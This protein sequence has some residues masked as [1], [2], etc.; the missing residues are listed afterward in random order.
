MSKRENR[1][2][3]N[4]YL[5]KQLGIEPNK[6][7]RYTLTPEQEKE[8]KAIQEFNNDSVVDEALHRGKLKE[9][10]WKVAW[11]KEE[12]VSV[13]VKNPDYKEETI[14]YDT[15]RLDMIEE[16]KQLSTVVKQYKRKAITDPHCLVLDISDPHFGK[17]ATV[18]GTGSFYNVDLAIERAIEASEKLIDAS[19]PYNIDK[20]FF[21]IG[22]DVLHT[23]NTTGSTTKGTSQ[24]TDGMWYDN[25]KIV[26]IVYSQII[27]RLTSIAPVSVIH[28]PSNHDYMTGFML[29][30]AIS[31][32][33][34]ANKNVTFDVTNRHRKYTTYGKNL[35]AFSHGDGA[36]VDQVPY[37]AAH[38]EPQMWANTYYRYCFLHHIH[39]KEVF[40][41]RS[42]KDYIGMTIEYL[43]SPSEA[44]QW[45]ADKGYVGAK[46]AIE[47]FIHH[48]TKGQV[49]R[50]THNF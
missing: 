45:H 4:N 17:L 28:C 30:D 43:R 20:V 23:D 15:L 49:A 32:Y 2:R 34:H 18:S 40:K 7:K 31:C 24:N 5:A 1:V 38:E 3:L 21:I 22:N 16:M 27:Q 6:C 26:R 9:N 46:I 50:H 11:V 19:K 10:T 12:G 35:L 8:Y 44:D 48:P 33:F 41:F 13:L 25:F 29:A 14:D 47:S 37:L 39:H 36:K 42:A